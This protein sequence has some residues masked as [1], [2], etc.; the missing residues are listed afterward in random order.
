MDI[1]VKA[2]FELEEPDS[3]RL[4]AYEGAQSIQGIARGLVLT[5]HF[6][7]TGVVRHRSPFDSDLQVYI[8]PPRRGSLEAIFQIVTDPGVQFIGGIG[9]AVIGNFLYDLSKTIFSRSVGKPSEPET[10]GVKDL[11]QERSGDLDA[12]VDAVEPT[13][14]LGHKAINSG[15]SNIVIVQGDNNI[16]NSDARTK[17]YVEH[18]K[19]SDI[20]ERQDVGIGSFNVNSGYGR[21]FFHD[22]GK[23]VPFIVHRHAQPGTMAAISYSLD[24]YANK[25][26]S[27]I[28]IEFLRTTAPDGRTKSIVITGASRIGRV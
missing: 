25:L 7:A 22:I 3:H 16:V 6:A 10:D 4:P 12:L 13:L 26:P 20:L 11:E 15:A 18:S 2:K 27:D 19:K 9:V 14:K 21:A 24:R 8:E 1:E 23:T 5:T 28:S 17:E